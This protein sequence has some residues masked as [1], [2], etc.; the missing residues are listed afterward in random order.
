MAESLYSILMSM[1]Q[2]PATLKKATKKAQP[3]IRA[4]YDKNVRRAMVQYYLDTYD[5]LSYKRQDPSPLF[6][7]YK[8]KSKLV[9]NGT[10][11]EVK[12]I[13]TDIDLGDYYSSSSYYHGGANDDDIDDE[14]DDGKWK[15]LSDIHNMTGLQYMLHIDDLREQYGRNNGAVMGSWILE[16]FEKGIH[17]RTNGWPRKKYSKKMVY[18]PKTIKPTPLQMAE[19]YAD[20]YF[21]LDTS[22]QYILSELDT[23]WGEMF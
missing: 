6:L 14:H 19:K 23:M 16:N 15:E 9:E 8:T 1:A 11:V 4:D 18:R 21:N 10:M 7:A 13:D 17:P 22:Y 5:P 2:N 3:K 20:K 12:V